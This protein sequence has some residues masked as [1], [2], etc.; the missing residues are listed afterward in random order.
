[1]TQGVE[2]P[3]SR[4]GVQSVYMLKLLCK[5]VHCRTKI[6]SGKVGNGVGNFF[7]DKG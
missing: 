4:S 7:Q 5:F 6:Y 3:A 2:V 1:L